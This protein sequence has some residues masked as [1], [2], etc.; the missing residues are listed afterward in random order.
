MAAM[1]WR[2]VVSCGEDEAAGNDA[3]ETSHRD[4]SGHVHPMSRS[5]SMTASATSSLSHT[6]ASGNASWSIRSRV[7][8]R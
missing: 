4:L 5:V 1:G 7:I 3:V 8:A 2:T 6:N